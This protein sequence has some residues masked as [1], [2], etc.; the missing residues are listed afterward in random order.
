MTRLKR[1]AYATSQCV[2]TRRVAVNYS[3]G[4]TLC[5]RETLERRG[6]RCV[7][8]LQ[9]LEFVPCVTSST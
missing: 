6:T 2:A 7:N 3:I 8:A 1:S 4:A 5:K 9:Q